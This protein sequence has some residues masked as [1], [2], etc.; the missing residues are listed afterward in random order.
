MN[1][2][3]S[4]L[5]RIIVSLDI[6][7]SI[8]SASFFYFLSIIIIFPNQYLIQNQWD[9]IKA[10][11]GFLFIIGIAFSLSLISLLLKQNIFPN[12]FSR[13]S[14][15]ISFGFVISYFLIW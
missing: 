14:S 2:K 10:F 4:R 3:E 11:K 12:T 8:V 13:I 1:K 6:F 7:L 15:C 9:I 5:Y